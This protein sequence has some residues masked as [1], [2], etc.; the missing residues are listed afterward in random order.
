MNNY[1]YTRNF[2]VVDQTFTLY[3]NQPY[4]K[5]FGSV[6]SNDYWT[7]DTT[8]FLDD[9]CFPTTF[10][11][12]PTMLTSSFTY[13]TLH[14]PS[15]TEFLTASQN[16]FPEP[17]S[18]SSST[19]SSISLDS[20]PF[21][22]IEH[23]TSTTEA[24]IAQQQ[25][26]FVIDQNQFPVAERRQKNTRTELSKEVAEQPSLSKLGS[27]GTDYYHNETV[28]EKRKAYSCEHCKRSFA[29]QYDVARHSRIHTGAKP[30]VCPCCQKAF[31]RSDARIRHFRTEINCMEGAKKIKRYQHSKA[32]PNMS[33]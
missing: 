21:L 27:F 17:V 6:M 30:Y 12:Q 32:R 14:S 16:T 20:T 3:N 25:V 19:R 7:D 1:L 31:A 13:P 18:A 5:D 28:K 4:T 11:T 26:P 29:R 22:P 2:T 33:S 9:C 10:T 15:S 24:F 8:G 23:I